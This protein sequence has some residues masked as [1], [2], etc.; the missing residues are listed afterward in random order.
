MLLQVTGWKAT[1][2]CWSCLAH[3][4]LSRANEGRSVRVSQSINCA[5][6]LLMAARNTTRVKASLRRARGR[7]AKGWGTPYSVFRSRIGCS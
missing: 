3:L 6:P 2:I 7:V 1:W 4:V 5:Q